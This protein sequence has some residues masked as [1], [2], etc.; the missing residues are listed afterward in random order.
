[1]PRKAR[2]ISATGVYHVMLRGINHQVIFHDE[3][4]YRK[5]I[6]ILQSQAHPQ[7]KDGRDLPPACEIYAYCLMTNHV[8]LLIRECNKSLGQLMKSIGVAY[9]SYVN[10]R[11]DRIG[12][13]FQDRF[14]SEPVADAGYFIRLLRYIHQNP[15]EAGMVASPDD[16]AWSS[17]HEY[18][19]D[20]TGICSHSV[21][22]SNMSWGELRDM[23]CAINKTGSLS[24]T[25]IEQ[26]LKM[27]DAQAKDCVAAICEA[28]NIERNLGELP[29]K[30]RDLVLSEALKAGIGVRQLARI[31]GVSHSTVHRLAHSTTEQKS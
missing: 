16:Y 14:L 7:D 4:D 19:R 23:V 31:T 18:Q 12:H 20:A 6:K 11:Y 2:A 10:K 24:K 30:K 5:F 1:M 28:N 27:S 26:T 8:H 21:P 13:L 22:F 15:V 3:L 17:W 25:A 29:R 9:V